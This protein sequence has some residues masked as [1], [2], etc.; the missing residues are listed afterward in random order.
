MLKLAILVYLELV[1]IG[2]VSLLTGQTYTFLSSINDY[3]SDLK[4]RQ[5]YFIDDDFKRC[6][7]QVMHGQ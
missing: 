5:L 3:Y 6:P 2:I 1:Q 7:A 4:R